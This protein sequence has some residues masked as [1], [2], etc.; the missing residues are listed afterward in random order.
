M[1]KLIATLSIMTA[2]GAGAFVLNS[3]MPASA[4]SLDTSTASTDSST[5]CS[6][7]TTVKDVLDQ[8]VTKGTINGDQETAIIDA[9]K[10]AHQAN[11]A[12]LGDTARW[13]RAKAIVGALNVAADKVGVSVDDFTASLM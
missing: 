2:L 6:A 3:V 5:S 11:K 12:N 4:G 8:L 9:L 10:S 7:R 1:K 13:P